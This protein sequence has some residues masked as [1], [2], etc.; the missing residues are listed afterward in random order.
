[1]FKV[2]IVHEDENKNCIGEEVATFDMGGYF[3]MRLLNM[4]LGAAIKKG[5]QEN[6][7][8]LFAIQNGTADSTGSTTE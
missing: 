4:S 1:M 3:P 5:M 2:M 8:R 6:V 7:K